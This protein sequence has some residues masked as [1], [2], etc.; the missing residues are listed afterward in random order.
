MKTL[1]IMSQKGG[2]G[3]TTLAVHLAAYAVGQKIKT[4]LIDLD[5]QASAHKW[6]ERRREDDPKSPKLD[7]VQGQ[8]NQLSGFLQLAKENG[9]ALVVIDTAPHSNSAAAIV[10]QLSDFVLM[11][12]R[13]ALFDLDAIASTVEIVTSANAH[14]A[15][16]LNAA[17]RGRLI[18]EARSALEGQGVSVLPVII[19]QRAAYSH[20]VIDGRAVHEYEPEGKAAQEI[21]RLYGTITRILGI[22]ARKRKAVA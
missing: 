13:P 14:S 17:P 22:H 18:D 9:L 3:K 4:A 19:Y 16:I 21:A 6:N 11:P 2:S 15:V 5:P 7:A 10:A 1:A 20:A 12:C 8:I